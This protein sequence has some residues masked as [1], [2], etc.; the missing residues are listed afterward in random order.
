ME[1]TLADITDFKDEEEFYAPFIRVHGA[2]GT[3]LLFKVEAEDT[4]P[5]ELELADELGRV[6]DA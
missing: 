6:L 4:S 1:G 5:A 3:V 2:R